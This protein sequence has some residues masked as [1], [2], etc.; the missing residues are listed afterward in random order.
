MNAAVLYLNER[1]NDSRF[2]TPETNSTANGDFYLALA[3]KG[4]AVDALNAWTNEYLDSKSWKRL[5]AAISR[6]ERTQGTYSIRVSGLAH[7]Y[8][9]SVAKHKEVSMSEVIEKVCRR[10]WE[11]II[12]ESRRC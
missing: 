4:E 12:G 7:H 2:P 6:S 10:E 1:L 9:S 3:K 8:L 11:R 5:R